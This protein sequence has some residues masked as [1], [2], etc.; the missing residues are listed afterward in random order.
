MYRYK[1]DVQICTNK[2]LV[3]K[4]KVCVC[5]CNLN[6]IIQCVHRGYLNLFVYSQNEKKKIN[7]TN[8]QK[9]RGVYVHRKRE[10]KAM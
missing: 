5:V 8:K 4:P 3:L 7:T 2:K 9:P 10:G 6:V 1:V